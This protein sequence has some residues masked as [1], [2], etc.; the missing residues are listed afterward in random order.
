MC[1]RQRG[2]FSRTISDT[3]FKSMLALNEAPA[4]DE[5]VEQGLPRAML[6]PITCSVLRDP[7][8]TSSGQTYEYRAILNWLKHHDTD[9][10]TLRKC[11]KTVYP[12]IALRWLIRDRLQLTSP[13]VADEEADNFQK[14]LLDAPPDPDTT[15][16]YYALFSEEADTTHETAQA[17]TPGR[18]FPAPAAAPSL[19]ESL[20]SWAQPAQFP[21][22]P[23]DAQSQPLAR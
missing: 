23:A 19:L 11:S 14:A 10:V 13:Y 17:A 9:P 16:F 20:R 2:A 15:F 3:L 4:I 12:N 18:S 1:C 5:A 6:C 7:H 8:V 22:S 21:S